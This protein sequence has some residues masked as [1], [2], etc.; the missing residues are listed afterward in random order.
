MQKTKVM[1]IGGETEPNIQINNTILENVEDFKYLG[2]IKTVDASCTK[3]IR[4]RIAMAKKRMIQLNNMWKERGIP[5][6]LKV[7]ILKA[8]IWPVVLY[9]S[10][11]WT[12]R[13]T[14]EN[15]INAAEMWFYRRLLRV[16]YTEKRTNESILKELNTEPQLLHTITKRKMRYLGHT[17][18]NK[19][20]DLMKTVLQGKM[21]GKR[22]RGRPSTSYMDNMTKKTAQTAASIYRQCVDRDEWRGL[23]RTSTLSAIV[24][25]ND[26]DR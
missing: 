19:R 21:E 4:T 11:A 15:H 20:C 22:K 18:R 13:K 23:I 12:L 7:K 24:T 17:V 9:G 16:S 8:L 10:E 3:D 5:K 1:H 2:S 14:D 25:H 26:A 6:V